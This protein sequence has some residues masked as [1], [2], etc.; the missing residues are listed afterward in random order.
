MGLPPCN[1]KNF[2]KA[3]LKIGLVVT[4][5]GKGSHTKIEDPKTSKANVVPHGDLSYVRDELFDWVIS[6]GYSREVFT[7]YL[8]GKK[9][10]LKINKKFLNK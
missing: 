1:S 2:I 6:L 5:G 8:Y 7:K 10:S 9:A 3:C 4:E